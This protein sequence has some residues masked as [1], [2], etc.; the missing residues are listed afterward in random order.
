MFLEGYGFVSFAKNMVNNIT[1]NTRKN[2]SSKYSQLLFHI[3][4]D[5]DNVF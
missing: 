4:I 3:A 2:L 1:E 5:A